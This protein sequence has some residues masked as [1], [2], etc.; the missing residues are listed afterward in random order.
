MPVVLPRSEEEKTPP[1]AESVEVITESI[2]HVMAA[3]DQ[4]TVSEGQ[5]NNEDDED[6][7]VLGSSLLSSSRGDTSR[8]YEIY[9]RMEGCSSDEE[10]QT[11]N[12]DDNNESEVEDLPQHLYAALNDDQFEFGEFTAAV[13][14]TAED[15]SVTCSENEWQGSVNGSSVDYNNSVVDITLIGDSA[16]F[17]PTF[18]ASQNIPEVQLDS[19]SVTTSAATVTVAVDPR[20]LSTGESEHSP[21]LPY[22]SIPPL[23]AGTIHFLCPV[24]VIQLFFLYTFHAL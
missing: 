23:S 3:E 8:N 13:S 7:A 20:E 6:G 12:D 15:I 10:T 18:E 1:S 24:E 5:A 21:S 2:S 14:C 4:N 16:S 17:Y 11:D 22:V 9:N 19:N